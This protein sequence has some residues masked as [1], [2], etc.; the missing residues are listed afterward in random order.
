MSLVL[1]SLE[2]LLQLRARAARRLDF[3]AAPTL[4]RPRAG[5]HAPRRHSARG[6]G[7]E[8]AESRPYQWGDDAR[9]IDWRVTARQGRPHTKVFVAE[10]ERPLWVLVERGD[11][12]RFGT[13]GR[14]KAV[15][16]ARLAAWFAWSARAGGDR[17]GALLV[18][19]DGARALPPR[20]GDGGVLALIAALI[21]PP[22]PGRGDLAAALA[23][24]VARVRAGDRVVLI[25]DFYGLDD[26]GAS[27][28][29]AKALAV[30]AKRA[31]LRLVRVYDRIEAT[32]PDEGVM[33]LV[34]DGEIREI[35]LGD[36][37]AASAWRDAFTRRGARLDELARRLGMPWQEVASD[38]ETFFTAAS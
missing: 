31:A 24:L 8:F 2:N 34:I 33:P 30:L 3:A 13:R 14:F 19:P 6:R 9:D 32:P 28:R 15:Q 23:G 22:P 35:D 17:V 36:P 1:P 37:A 38:D 25:G 16:A 10:R 20:G 7:L 11:S 26:D 29:C 27:E 12:L 18:D 4:A 21:A 5:E